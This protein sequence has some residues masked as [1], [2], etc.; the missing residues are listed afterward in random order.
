MRVKNDHEMIEM[1]SLPIDISN[2][3]CRYIEYGTD[4]LYVIS[5][6]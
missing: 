3:N 4:F 2:E 1:F 5:N 6:D